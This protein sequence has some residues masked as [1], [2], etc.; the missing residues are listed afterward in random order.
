MSQ[1]QKNQAETSLLVKELNDVVRKIESLIIIITDWLLFV[2]I[3]EEMIKIIIFLKKCGFSD[4]NHSPKASLCT[5][6][7]LERF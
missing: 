2:Q 6:G 4:W 5:L 3:K 7:D 1:A